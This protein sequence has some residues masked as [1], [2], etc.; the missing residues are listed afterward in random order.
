MY[1]ELI[2]IGFSRVKVISIYTKFNY[3]EFWTFIC[4]R[5]IDTPMLNAMNEIS[6]SKSIALTMSAG[7]SFLTSRATCINR[8]IILLTASDALSCETTDEAP[9]LIF[10]AFSL[11]IFTLEVNP[12]N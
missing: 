2:K 8:S 4:S 1:P 3:V 7:I 9:S 5:S 6:A 10:E 12:L 11:K